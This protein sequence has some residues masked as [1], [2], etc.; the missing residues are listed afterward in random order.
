MGNVII[1][2]AVHFGKLCPKCLGSGKLKAMQAA[3]YINGPTVRAA[4][5][6]VPCDCCGG[7]GFLKGGTNGKE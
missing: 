4:D 3:K 1:K 6:T 2:V 5:T 7:L